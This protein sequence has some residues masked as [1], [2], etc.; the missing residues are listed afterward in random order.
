M[1]IT[2]KY[3]DFLNGDDANSGDTDADA[4]KTIQFAINN[5]VDGG[6]G[7]QINIKSNA[8]HVLTSPVNWQVGYGPTN[9]PDNPLIIRGYTTVED[10]GG[11]G[12][13]DGNNVV[14]NLFVFFF[15]P[16][17]VFYVDLKL[18][19]TTDDV[20]NLPN[21][22][23]VIRCE[24]FNGGISATLDT[25]SIGT[26]II[27]CYLHTGS[28]SAT[29]IFIGPRSKVYATFIEGHSDTAILSSN[30]D[31][32]I[33]YNLIVSG[34]G[35]GI[36][37]T[38]NDHWI[39]GNTIIGDGTAGK[40]GIIMGAAGEVNVIL[41]N[42]FKDWT[43]AGSAGINFSVGGNTLVEGHNL[44]HNNAADR[45]NTPL[46]FG[47]DL[48]AND[49]TIDPLFVNPASDDYSIGSSIK[50]GGYPLS[51][52]GSTTSTFVDIGAAQRREGPSGL[53]IGE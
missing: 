16:T 10:D 25:N 42:I 49:K 11:I 19:N 47:L 40:F 51:L 2:H 43:G 20:L 45:I 30:L 18:H 35:G 50:E 33:L 38:N 22:C 32:Q 28:P 41:N 53:V 27:E 29:A 4:Y 31:T 5:I 17:D 52:F 14:G 15:H 12:E 21:F 48:R 13:I 8:V 23:A 36:S 34:G 26:K 37:I 46:I 3:V 7:N 24:L 6:A 9:T 44:F 39:I 1:A